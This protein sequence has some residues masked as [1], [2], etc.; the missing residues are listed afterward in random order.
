M[1]PSDIVVDVLNELARLVGL[2]LFDKFD[3]KT[4]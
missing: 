1:K 4:I 3:D 2:D